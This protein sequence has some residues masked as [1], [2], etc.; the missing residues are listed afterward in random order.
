LLFISKKYVGASDGSNFQLAALH[1]QQQSDLTAACV[2]NEK[3]WIDSED[4]KIQ[5]SSL[6][7][8]WPLH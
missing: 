1:I 2:I 4:K 5:K 6:S 3:R 7:A 8:S